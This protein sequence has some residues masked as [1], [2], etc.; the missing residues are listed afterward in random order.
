MHWS[1]AVCLLPPATGTV[2]D[3]WRGGGAGLTL[4]VPILQQPNRYGLFLAQLESP[5]LQQQVPESPKLRLSSKPSMLAS[6]D[7]GGAEA[8]TSLHH[9]ASLAS[10]SSVGSR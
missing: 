6:S 1:D 5:K 3:S 2:G 9:E 7:Q 10:M 4:C 8:T